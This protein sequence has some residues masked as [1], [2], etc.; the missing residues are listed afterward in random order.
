MVLDPEQMGFHTTSSDGNNLMA[1]T[2]AFIEGEKSNATTPAFTEKEGFVS[3]QTD[4]STARKAYSIDVEK[5]ADTN[6]RFITVLYPAA[7]DNHTIT[8]ASSGAFTDARSSVKVTID[9]KEHVLTNTNL[10]F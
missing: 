6:V 8:A 10:T 4:T 1:R 7:D 9:G 3:Y 5:S 2:F